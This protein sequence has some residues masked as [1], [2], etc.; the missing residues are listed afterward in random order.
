MSDTLYT[1]KAKIQEQ[2][3]LVFDGVQ[4]EDNLT[5][6]DYGIEH[7]SMLDLHEKMQIFVTEMPADRTMAL[8]V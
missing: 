6:E 3:R 2:Y 7:G 1:I 5:L 8:E 4:L